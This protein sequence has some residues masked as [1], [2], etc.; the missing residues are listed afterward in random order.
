MIS[1]SLV[2]VCTQ[3]LMKRAR[4]GRVAAL[5][6][7]A[8]T[9]AVRN[10]IREGKTHQIPSAMQV[11]GKFGMQTMEAAVMELVTSGQITHDEARRR[12][13]DLAG[14][15]ERVQAVGR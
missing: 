15:D 10:M 6:I 12:L 1:E 13:P 8:G 11:G 14:P 9:P 5:E 7:L 4:G 2:G 3:M